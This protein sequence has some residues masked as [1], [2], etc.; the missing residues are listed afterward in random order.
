MRAAADHRG[1]TIRALTS[2]AGSAASAGGASTVRSRLF[3]NTSRCSSPWSFLRLDQRRIRSMVLLPG[4]QGVTD[5]VSASRRGCRRQDRAVH[6]RDRKPDRLDHATALV[7]RH[8][9]SSAVSMR[10]DFCGRCPPSPNSRRSM[11]PAMSSSGCRG[12][13]MDVV[14]S[15]VDYSEKPEFTEAVAHKVYYGPVYFRRESEP[16]MTLSLA[17]TRREPAS[18]SRRSTSSSSGTSFRRSKWASTATPMW[19]MPRAA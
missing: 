10:C 1:E 5:P 19:S 9:R 11:P 2:T 18:A 16:Y 15:G 4:A 3:S 7:G 17:G 8:A 6:H 13:T 12:S 14:G